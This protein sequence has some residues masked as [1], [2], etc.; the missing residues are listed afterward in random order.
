VKKTMARMKFVLNERRLALL[1][2]REKAAA[3]QADGSSVIEES[4]GSLYEDVPS[5]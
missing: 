2:A 1:Q 4:R 5:V 3:K